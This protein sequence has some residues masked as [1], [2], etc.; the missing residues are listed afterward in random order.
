MV[1]LL[2]GRPLW[3]AMMVWKLVSPSPGMLVW[4]SSTSVVGVEDRLGLDG[5][6]QDG[7]RA[8]AARR[9]DADLEDLLRAGVD[10][11]G[12]QLADEGQRGEE[13]DARRA[14]RRPGPSSASAGRT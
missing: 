9:R 4:M 8:G 2:A 7:L 14:R 1:A 12:R 6:L 11:L 3:A 13:Q 5:P 10:E